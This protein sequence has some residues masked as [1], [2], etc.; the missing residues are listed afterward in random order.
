MAAQELGGIQEMMAVIRIDQLISKQKYDVIIIDTPPAQNAIAF[1]EAPHKLKLLLQASLFRML[2]GDHSQNQ[3]FKQQFFSQGILQSLKLFLGSQMIEDLQTFFTSF[4]PISEKLVERAENVDQIL[5]DNNSR[6]LLISTPLRHP[7]ELKIYF[8]HLT[9]KN[10][11]IAGL[12]LNRSP[13]PITE[14]EFVNSNSYVKFFEYHKILRERQDLLLN[15]VNDLKYWKIY[16]QLH[17]PQ[18]IQGLAQLST[19]LP[20]ISDVYDL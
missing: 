17:P 13:I 15:S 5:K 19:S 10:Y 6:F 3:S 16:E 18:E 4:F 12:L 11:T 20:S 8:E 1:L 14:D 2:R 9:S 7:E